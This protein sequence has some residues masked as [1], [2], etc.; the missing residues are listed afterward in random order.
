MKVIPVFALCAL[1]FFSSFAQNQEFENIAL[2]QILKEKKSYQLDSVKIYVNKYAVKAP[3]LKY[4]SG[5]NYWHIK[6]VLKSDCYSAK[7]SVNNAGT[8]KGVLKANDEYVKFGVRKKLPKGFSI[9]MDVYKRFYYC[10]KV[11]V[12]IVI[13]YDYWIFTQVLV[14]FDEE[15]NITSTDSHSYVT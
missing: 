9:L 11:Y 8:E 3:D 12:L 1:Y 6:G 7:D 4:F 5:R 2:Q 13:K 15:G 14:T 10:N